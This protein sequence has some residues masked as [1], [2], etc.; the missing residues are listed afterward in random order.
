[1]MMMM[2]AFNGGKIRS[3]EFKDPPHGLTLTLSS[4][5]R[6]KTDFRVFLIFRSSFLMAA[7]LLFPSFLRLQG[8]REREREKGS[9]REGGGKGVIDYLFQGG[10]CTRRRPSVA[11]CVNNIGWGS[12]LEQ[13]ALRVKIP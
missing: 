12:A 6:N 4:A 7:S 5:L 11:V 10:K 1:M 9:W 13:A 8:E 3:H 2:M